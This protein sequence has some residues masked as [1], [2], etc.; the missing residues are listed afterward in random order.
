MMIFAERMVYFKINFFIDDAVCQDSIY[1]TI[2]VFQVKV[3]VPL[4][5]QMLTHVNGSTF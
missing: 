4:V 1:A 5:C 2:A 3:V